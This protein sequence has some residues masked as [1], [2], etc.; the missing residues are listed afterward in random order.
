M[1][2]TTWCHHVFTDQYQ[3]VPAI[4]ERLLLPYVIIIDQQLTDQWLTLRWTLIVRCAH[5]FI[6]QP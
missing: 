5:S 4:V 2:S 6:H 1:A 3:P